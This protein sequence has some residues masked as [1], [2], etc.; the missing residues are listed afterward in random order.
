MNA[1]F[2][3]LQSER[4]NWNEYFLGIAKAVATRADCTRR[5]VGAVLVDRQSRIIGTGYNGAG[6][7]ALGCLSDGECPRGPPQHY[8]RG[9]LRGL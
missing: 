8:R 6:S 9:A 1:T 2:P 5:K 3:N 4:P 7:G